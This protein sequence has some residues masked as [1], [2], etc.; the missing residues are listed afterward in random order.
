M[1]STPFSSILY[2]GYDPNYALL[3]R[4][5]LSGIRRFA[6]AHGWEVAML[7]PEEATP[8][9]V[10]NAMARFHAVGCIVECWMAHH[11]LPPCLFGSVPAVFFNPPERRAWRG[12]SSIV[13]DEVAVA[14][15]AFRELSSGL[16]SG[17]AVVAEGPTHKSPWARKRIAAFRACCRKDGKSCRVFPERRGEDESQRLARLERWA[18]A[19]PLHCAIF[20]VND[21][22][23]AEVAHALASAGRLLP[24]SA[25]L[26]GADAVETPADGLP[27]PP[28][29]SVKIDFE[30]SGYLAAK[31]LRTLQPHTDNIKAQRAN[32][33]PKGPFN[34]CGDLV[35]ATFGPLFVERRASTRGFGRREPFVMKALEMIRREACDGLSAANLASRFP[36]SR[37]LFEL[38]FRKAMGHSVMDEIQH[39]RMQHVFDLLSRPD[40]P[41]SAIASFSGFDCDRE[42]RRQ[43]RN[44]TGTSMRE[45]RKTRR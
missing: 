41:I 28:I 20:A 29:S 42:L 14:R 19:L 25:T 40:F 9:A 16:P 24:R 37:K 3:R 7:S 5:R 1:A 8:E 35:A 12:V 33:K 22:I 21:L 2:I 36:G 30:L 34:A 23:A 10:R 11:D 39:V 18:A 45:W 4:R 44:R 27:T 26:V 38:R 17:Y 15:A 6:K 32:L 13:C 31:L 43:F